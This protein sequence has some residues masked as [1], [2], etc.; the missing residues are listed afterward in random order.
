MCASWPFSIER[1]DLGTV[2]VR[3]N[4]RPPD[5]GRRSVAPSCRP[6]CMCPW[7]CG[8][9]LLVLSHGAHDPDASWGATVSRTQLLPVVRVHVAS[10]C[11]CFPMGPMTQMHAAVGRKLVA[12]KCLLLC[13]CPRTCGVM[14]LVFCHGA[15]DPDARRG[16]MQVNRIQM[17][18]AVHVPKDMWCHAVGALPWGP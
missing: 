13:T 15:L 14:L 17:S 1:A 2:R 18:P 6:L 12:S 8:V 10:C 9:V 11:W 3:L 4:F 16:G 5:V 7:A